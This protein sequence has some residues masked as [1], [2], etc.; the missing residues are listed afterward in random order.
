M[1]N[2]RRIA[3]QRDQKLKAKRRDAAEKAA[4]ALP[5]PDAAE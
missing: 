3:G 2:F 4:A 5:A 1:R